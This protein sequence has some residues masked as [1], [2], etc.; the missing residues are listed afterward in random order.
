MQWGIHTIL[1]Q[2][3]NREATT[4]QYMFL[5]DY[6][7]Y[8][9]EIATVNAKRLAEDTEVLYQAPERTADTPWCFHPIT[10]FGLGVVLLIVLIRQTRSRALLNMVVLLMFLFTGVVGCLIVFLG[11][12]TA[13]P[14]TVP[15]WNILWANPLNLVALVFV[16][17]RHIP[18]FASIY[19][20][21]YAGI[22][23]V[24]FVAWGICQPAV[25]V[26]SVFLIGLMLYLCLHLKGEKKRD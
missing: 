1:G 24:A 11:A 9:L 10:V 13:H 2:R 6:L 18:R 25:P 15:N 26:A 22:L 5:P 8:G 17:R 16:L 3:G 7:M 12:F 21:I 19:L 4:F 20:K 23:V 14:I